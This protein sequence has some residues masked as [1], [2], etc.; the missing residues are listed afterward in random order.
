MYPSCMGIILIHGPALGIQIHFY[1][2][3]EIKRVIEV[4]PKI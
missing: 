2:E 1:E 3:V 4:D